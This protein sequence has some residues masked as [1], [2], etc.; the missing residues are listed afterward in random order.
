MCSTRDSLD[1]KDIF[2]PSF[3]HRPGGKYWDGW[4]FFRNSDIWGLRHHYV[5]PLGMGRFWIGT[6][7]RGGKGVE[8]RTE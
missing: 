5:C 7:W 2:F 3:V 1:S 6:S 8:K 4:D